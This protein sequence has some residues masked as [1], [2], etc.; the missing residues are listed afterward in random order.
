MLEFVSYLLKKLS[1]DF[2]FPKPSGVVWICD[3]LLN[4]CVYIEFIDQIEE[5]IMYGWF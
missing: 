5:V 3:F 1:I 4:R 2:D